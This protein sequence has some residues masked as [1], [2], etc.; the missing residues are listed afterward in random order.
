MISKFIA[1]LKSF[2]V[3][4]GEISY[5]AGRFFKEFLFS[6]YEFKEFLRQC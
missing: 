3:E 6:P 5:F 2:L 4:V 1:S